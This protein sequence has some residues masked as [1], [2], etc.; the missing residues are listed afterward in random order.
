[1]DFYDIKLEETRDGWIV[2]DCTDPNVYELEIPSHV[3]GKPVI[4]IESSA[5]N[6]LKDLETVWIP[7]TVTHIEGHAFANCSNLTAVISESPDLQLASFV[8]NRCKKLE[9]FRSAG[10]VAI[11][12]FA[13]ASCVELS[14]FCGKIDVLHRNGF[15]LCLKLNQPLYFAEKVYHFNASAFQHCPAN[16]LHFL[17]N[18]DRVDGL[19]VDVLNQLKWYCGP[20]SNVSNLAYLGCN[21]IVEEH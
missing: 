9:R 10:T 6:G 1:M 21:I 13:F 3:D 4:Q 19:E 18:V 12:S 8:F 15:N 5:F 11:G 7:E 17:G 16:E 14:E 20:N 2:I